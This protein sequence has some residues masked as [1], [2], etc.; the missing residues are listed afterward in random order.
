MSISAP[1][2][3]GP[4]V[5]IGRRLARRCVAVF[6]GLMASVVAPTEVLAHGA[7]KSSVPTAGAS[8][9]TVPTELR[10]LFNERV[11]LRLSKVMLF[12]PDGASIP[13]PSVR[14]GDASEVLLVTGPLMA[15]APGRYEVRWQVAGA[16]G[17]PTRGS[18]TFAIR[19]GAVRVT[20]DREMVRPAV[21]N[22]GGAKLVASAAATPR[23]QPAP[24]APDRVNGFDERSVAYVLIRWLQYVAVFLMVGTVVLSR[25]VLPRAQEPGEP[26]TVPGVLVRDRSLRIGTLASGALL[27]LQAARFFAQRETLRGSGDF[28]L[29]VTAADMLL[30]SAW[31]TGLLLVV[32]GALLT[33]AVLRRMSVVEKGATPL[34]VLG[35]GIAAIGLGLSGHQAA[36]PIGAPLAVLVDAVHVLGTAGWLGTLAALVMSGLP[37][38]RFEEAS[39][40]A[41]VARILRAFSPVALISAGVAGATGL[42]LAAVNLGRVPAL[43]ES[44]YGRVLLIKLSVLAFVVATGAYNWRRVLPS[45]GTAQSTLALRRSATAEVLVA[46]AVVAVT[47][48]L[49]ATPNAAMR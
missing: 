27:A 30:G 28:R 14:F 34:L 22:Q 25:I 32:L 49:V 21:G 16:D 29:D 48:V 5:R 13:I 31:G 35:L 47:A 9:D 24:P 7:L 46:I 45:L 33:L 36:S 18:F 6:L 3:A 40:H 41:Q 37:V 8:L 19:D 1:V 20:G 11:E 2:E 4:R 15:L 39:D 38:L 26:Q 43:W 44:E 42:T 10:L 12:G 23:M 17:H